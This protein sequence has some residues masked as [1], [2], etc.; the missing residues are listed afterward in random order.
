MTNKNGFSGVILILIVVA[1]VVIGGYYIFSNREAAPANDSVQGQ[2]SPCNLNIQANQIVSF[3]LNIQ[4]QISIGQQAPFICPLGLFEGQVGII[5]AETTLGAP[6]NTFA[7]LM[8]SDPNFDYQPGIHNFSGT[9][10]LNAPV[11]SG[12]TVILKFI[13][14]DPTGAPPVFFTI[15][16]IVQ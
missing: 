5:E 6:L 2:A 11:S 1:V 15:P 12:Q 8:I 7:S 9:V 14:E 16:V 13:K 3:P 10:T 4:G